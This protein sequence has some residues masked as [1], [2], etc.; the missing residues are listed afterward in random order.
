MN[1]S[2][3]NST[4]SLEQGYGIFSWFFYFT[5]LSTSDKISRE[6]EEGENLIAP[7]SAMNESLKTIFVLS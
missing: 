1:T 6:S 5:W 2:K 3:F 7:S 4:T